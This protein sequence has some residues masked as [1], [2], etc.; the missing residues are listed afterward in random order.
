ME[1]TAHSLT[2][3]DWIGVAVAASSGVGLATFPVVGQRF[4]TMFDDLGPRAALPLLTR[5]VLTTWFPL[6]LAL[7]VVVAIAIGLRGARALAARRAWIVG[8]FL[9]GAAGF[10]TCFVGVYMPVFALAGAIKAD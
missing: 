3:L 9:V 5:L 10:A 6:G 2:V 8:A 7:F 4:A 1:A